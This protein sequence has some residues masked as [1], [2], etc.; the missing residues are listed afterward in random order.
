MPIPWLQ[1]STILKCHVL[2][3]LIHINLM[4]MWNKNQPTE[5]YQRKVQHE[6]HLCY[7]IMLTFCL[8]K[9][10][11]TLTGMVRRRKSATNGTF[12]EA[13][14][15]II[16]TGFIWV[17]YPG[18]VFYMQSAIILPIGGYNVSHVLWQKPLLEYNR[19]AIY[20]LGFVFISVLLPII[21]SNE[22]MFR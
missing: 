18:I 16:W 17:T 19:E 9:S 14:F 13:V 5:L 10:A 11:C 20:R 15:D 2:A 21:E 8:N 3:F 12:Q 7:I 4:M 22:H 6:R 1:L